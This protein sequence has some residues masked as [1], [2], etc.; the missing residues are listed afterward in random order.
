MVVIQLKNSSLAAVNNDE[1]GLMQN[2][3]KVLALFHPG[4]QWLM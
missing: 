4:L 2:P 1:D 3:T